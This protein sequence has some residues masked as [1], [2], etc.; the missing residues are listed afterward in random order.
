MIM[1]ASATGLCHTGTILIHPWKGC[2]D[3]SGVNAFVSSISIMSKEV[4]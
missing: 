4:V 3:S 1:S 2:F